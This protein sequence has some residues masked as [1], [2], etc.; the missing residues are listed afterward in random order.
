MRGG[1]LKASS[2]LEV[3]YKK[4]DVWRTLGFDAVVIPMA[5][6]CHVFSYGISFIFY[7]VI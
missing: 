1:L 3:C 6:F 5:T 2:S 4:S 7:L